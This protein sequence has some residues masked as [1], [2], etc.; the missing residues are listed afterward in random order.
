MDEQTL[1]HR[2]YKKVI[3]FFLC[4]HKH[5]T[6]NNLLKQERNRIAYIGNYG[7]LTSTV[8]NLK[9]LSIW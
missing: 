9:F 3:N 5:Y 7:K 6:D 2:H 1:Q 4:H 8:S